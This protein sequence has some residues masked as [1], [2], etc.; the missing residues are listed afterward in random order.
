M[1]GL[2]GRNLGCVEVGAAVPA[3]REECRSGQAGHT[4]GPL[5]GSESSPTFW[6]SPPLQTSHEIVTEGCISSVYSA[7]NPDN[8]EWTTD[9]SHRFQNEFPIHLS[10]TPSPLG[11]R[12]TL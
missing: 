4:A 12:E 5:P 10:T 7:P 1:P 6:C 3:V 9:D 2:G 11:A 8:K